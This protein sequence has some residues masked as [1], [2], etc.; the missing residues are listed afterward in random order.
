MKLICDIIHKNPQTKSLKIFLKPEGDVFMVTL[1]DRD[2]GKLLDKKIE[3]DSLRGN[4]DF[5]RYLSEQRLRTTFN[6]TEVAA[7]SWYKKLLGLE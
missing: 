1:A 3:K 4:D 2:T 6:G 7:F 5:E